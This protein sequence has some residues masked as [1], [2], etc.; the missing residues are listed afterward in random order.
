MPLW[1]AVLI[2]VALVVWAR[3]A[4]SHD[5]PGL[6]GVQY[7]QSC[8]AGGDCEPAP[9]EDI[10]ERRDG[11]HWQNLKFPHYMV[12]SCT[13]RRCHVFFGESLRAD[14]KTEI[15]RRCHASFWSRQVLEGEPL[16][17]LGSRPAGC[18]SPDGW[19]EGVLE[20]HHGDS[21]HLLHQ[22]AA[23]KLVV[24]LR[25]MISAAISLSR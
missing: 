11:W 19:P 14:M 2:P 17:K 18:R 23:R 24:P 20:N 7:P 16:A 5:I 15:S 9:C 13:D 8:C 12:R 21:S 6:P 10:E 25:E 4:R 3:P 22:F 1:P